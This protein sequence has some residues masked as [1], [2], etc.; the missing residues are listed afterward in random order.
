MTDIIP[1]AA[2]G[3]YMGLSNVVTASSTTIAVLIGGPFIDLVNRS[4]GIG[5]GE[6]LELGLGIAYYALGALLLRPVVEPPRH[7]L[8]QEPLADIVA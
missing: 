1:K 7:A 4:L 3:R 8:A 6:R 5:M 2:S